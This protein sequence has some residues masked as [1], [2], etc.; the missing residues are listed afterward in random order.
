MN[1]IPNNYQSYNNHFKSGSIMPMSHIIPSAGSI[2]SFKSQSNFSN[3]SLNSP[4]YYANN[5]YYKLQNNRANNN[6]NNYNNNNVFLP[7]YNLT[8]NPNIINFNPNYKNNSSNN[9]NNLNN[10][11]NNN[12]LPEYNLAANP[13]ITNFNPHSRKKNFEKFENINFDISRFRSKFNKNIPK[14]SYSFYENT[15]SSETSNLRSMKEREL[16][17]YRDNETIIFKDLRSANPYTKEQREQLQSQ[18]DEIK[19]KRQNLELEL[20]KLRSQEFREVRKNKINSY[21]PSAGNGGKTRTRPNVLNYVSR[22][23]NQRR[24][25]EENNKNKYE[26]LKITSPFN[27]YYNKDENET[28]Y[29]PNSLN[30]SAPNTINSYDKK[31]DLNNF[32]I[33]KETRH[34]SLDKYQKKYE[35]IYYP[36]N[37]ND[38][39]KKINKKFDYDSDDLL[40][41]YFRKKKSKSLDT[42]QTP[43][44]LN[45][46]NN[47]KINNDLNEN[48]DINNKNVDYADYDNYVNSGNDEKVKNDD[49]IFNESN[50]VNDQSQNIMNN[51][52]LSYY[53]EP[54]RH[55]R[56]Y[57]SIKSISHDS[58][59]SEYSSKSRTKKPRRRKP[60]ERYRKTKDRTRDKK[61]RKHKRRSYDDKKRHNRID[62]IDSQ[63]KRIKYS[64][65]RTKDR[66]GTTSSGSFSEDKYH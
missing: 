19:A 8:T 65:K 52:N 63:N 12:F 40:S 20:H 54:R 43:E 50:F 17:S 44:S 29:D 6:L 27:R 39:K 1:T 49:N 57:N 28:N 3:S 23:E 10:F 34:L 62:I 42:N 37:E 4:N 53:V 26:N 35:P 36:L 16:E 66:S 24:I 56:R 47:C 5:N 30:L 45:M 18:L 59:Y 31:D 41:E 46:S 60:K 7:E 51:S 64:T 38:N 13:N 22:A 33:K 55:N 48:K 21:Q 14:K 58:N 11:N 25:R 61:R 15:D 32:K 9:S 2:D